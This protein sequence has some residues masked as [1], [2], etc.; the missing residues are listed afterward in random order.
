[1]ARKGRSACKV[2]FCCGKRCVDDHSLLVPTGDCFGGFR[3]V[4][5]AVYSNNT[6]AADI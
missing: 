4:G 3:Q 5:G 1:M 6:E 2:D